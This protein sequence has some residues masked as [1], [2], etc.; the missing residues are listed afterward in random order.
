MSNSRKGIVYSDDTIEKMRIANLGKNNPNY[1]KKQ[2]KVHFDAM[3]KLSKKVI[4][5]FPNG[6]TKHFDSVTECKEYM[7]TKYNISG[8]TIKKLLKENSPLHLS[9][10]EKNHYPYVYALNGLII[11]YEQ[12]DYNEIC[13]N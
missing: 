2:T 5:I 1:G 6:E 12:E 11:R 3:K 13:S 7:K 10:R 4:V 9:D 8:F